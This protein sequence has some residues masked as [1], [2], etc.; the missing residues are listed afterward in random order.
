MVLVALWEKFCGPLSDLKPTRACSPG[1][2]GQIYLFGKFLNCLRVFLLG[3]K[4]WT[5]EMGGSKMNRFWSSFEANYKEIRCKFVIFYIFDVKN[6]FTPA[7]LSQRPLVRSA[8]LNPLD[9][10]TLRVG[11]FPTTY[12][13]G[14]GHRLADELKKS[15]ETPD[16]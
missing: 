8:I 1:K 7:T 5:L 2:N 16:Y 12:V 11:T 15:H 14:M 3:L 4:V 9:T 6:S 13:G 10:T